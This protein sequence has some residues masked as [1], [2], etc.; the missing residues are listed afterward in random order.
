MLDMLCSC[1]ERF[2]AV[3]HLD[4]ICAVL[5]ALYMV[6]L[7]GMMYLQYA[8]HVANLDCAYA[9]VPSSCP[10]DSIYTAYPGVPVSS[11]AGK[12]VSR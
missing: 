10:P 2:T 8:V 1:S 7:A 3:E 9:F 5:A 4:V 11:P 6:F 12:L